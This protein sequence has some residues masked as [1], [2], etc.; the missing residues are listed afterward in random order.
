MRR[1]RLTALITSVVL[2]SAGA[3]AA[4]EQ[5]QTKRAARSLAVEVVRQGF[6]DLQLE[7]LEP[8]SDGGTMDMAPPRRLPNAPQAAEGA[9]LTRVRVR[10]TREGD[11]V[12][13]K[14]A[15]VFDDSQPAD[16][17]GPKYGP[18]EQAL[19]TYL[20]R[21]GETVGVEEFKRYGFV[22]L[23]LRVVKAQPEPAPASL[24]VAPLIV[25]DLES[26][27]VV[28]FVPENS[29]LNSYRLT[30]R[31]VSSKD[32]VAL[33]LYDASPNGR[34]SQTSQ[35][36]PERPLMRPGA[37]YETSFHINTGGG[38]MTP[39]GFVPEPERQRAVVVGTVMF[40]DG[41]Y[42]GEVE[43]AA[44]IAARDRGRRIQLARAVALVQK[45]LDAPA[46]DAAAFKE[47]KAQVASMRIDVDPAVVEELLARFPKLPAQRGRG[48]LAAMVMN[49]LKQG[50]EEVTYRIKDAEAA[51][52]RGPES[53][54]ARQ[55]LLFL[56]GQLEEV[57]GAPARAGGR[58]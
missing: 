33:D 4:Q 17:P 36:T 3:P 55:G 35:G 49:G 32:I 42:E 29:P 34:S 37:V 30:L 13:I 38:R 1:L 58:Q 40:G 21:E 57:V 19:A 45:I 12:R 31:N 20:A 28:S 23:V 2:L 54:D 53:F 50:R 43:T 8:P 27:E 48:N 10:A 51:V 39:Q 56:K 25:N 14:V 16:A 52:R 46:L 44:D 18:K 5:R 41:S 9:P 11:A 6:S 26:V 47:L 7:V 22:P 24:T 15:V